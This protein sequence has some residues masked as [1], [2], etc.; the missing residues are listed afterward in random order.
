MAPLRAD[1]RRRASELGQTPVKRQDKTKGWTH[2]ER[3]RVSQEREPDPDP[4]FFAAL[5][6]ANGHVLYPPEREE[7]EIES[8]AFAM[9]LERAYA[10]AARV[11]AEN[12][13]T[14]SRVVSRLVV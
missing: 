11:L 8:K 9:A 4:A 2:L 14:P 1:R 6:P 3:R 5:K 7:E 12:P 13:D 10:E